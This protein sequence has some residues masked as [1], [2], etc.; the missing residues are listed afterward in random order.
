MDWFLNEKV[1]ETRKKSSL[2]I[3]PKDR[4]KPRGLTVELLF[5]ILPEPIYR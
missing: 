2:K 1:R 5:K 4:K 3:R